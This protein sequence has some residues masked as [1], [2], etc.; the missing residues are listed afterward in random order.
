MAWRRRVFF[1]A[2]R[3]DDDEGHATLCRGT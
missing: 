1:E 3:G 2:G